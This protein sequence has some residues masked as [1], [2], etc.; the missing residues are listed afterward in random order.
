[1]AD[2]AE[3]KVE[4]SLLT[5]GDDDFYKNFFFDELP[6]DGVDNNVTVSQ[7]LTINT[8]HLYSE[9]EENKENCLPGM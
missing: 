4:F 7:L 6:I 1:M 2:N 8:Q 9:N 5:E 3:E